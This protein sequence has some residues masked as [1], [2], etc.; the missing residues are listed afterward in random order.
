MSS[1]LEQCN[2]SDNPGFV[3]VSLYVRYFYY[4]RNDFVVMKL[5]VGVRCKETEIDLPKLANET[6]DKGRR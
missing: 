1:L 6:G 3:H 2:H 5:F 4:T